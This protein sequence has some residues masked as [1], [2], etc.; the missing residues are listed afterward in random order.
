MNDALTDE[1]H[2]LATTA[3]QRLVEGTAQLR[4]AYQGR[5]QTSI[6]LKGR[7]RLVDHELVRLWTACAMPASA[8]LVAVGGYGRGELFPASDVDLRTD[9]ELFTRM[10]RN[11]VDNALN[12]AP[13]TPERPGV[14]TVRISHDRFSHAL[15]LQVEDNGPGVPAGE[16]QR[17]FEPFYRALGTNV[18]GSGLGLPIVREIAERHHAVVELSAGQAGVG[19]RIRIRF[20]PAERPAG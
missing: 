1:L 14:V 5:P 15:V 19:T 20:S 6:L 13:S 7:A 4:D 11:L 17:I 2:T 3:R 12:Y 8:A 10:L 9:P 16:R 18:D